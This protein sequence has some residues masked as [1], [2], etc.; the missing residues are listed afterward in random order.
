MHEEVGIGGESQHVSNR[1]TQ[2]FKDTYIGQTDSERY[3]IWTVVEQT[4]SVQKTRRLSF[5]IS[6]ES[7][8]VANK[9]HLT[10]KNI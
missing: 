6:A 1:R 8:H 9:K 3:T 7:E 5:G 10:S 4:K 2:L